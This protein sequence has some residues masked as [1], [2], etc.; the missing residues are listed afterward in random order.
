VLESFFRRLDSERRTRRKGLTKPYWR[1]GIAATFE[2]LLSL[3][4][5]LP[6]FWSQ[7]NQSFSLAKSNKLM[8]DS[9]ASRAR[10]SMK[11]IFYDLLIAACVLTDVGLV[12]FFLIELAIFDFVNILVILLSG[13]IFVA[14]FALSERESIFPQRLRRKNLE[15]PSPILII[16]DPRILPERR[17]EGEIKVLARLSKQKPR[18]EFGMHDCPEHGPEKCAGSMMMLHSCNAPSSSY[19]QISW[20]E[21]RLFAPRKKENESRPSLS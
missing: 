10:L 4:G 19:R 1:L 16:E 12:G 15:L 7:E 6:K 9:K 5:L 21:K 20:E 2:S 17:G 11:P 18:M 14:T 3:E 8:I 13:I